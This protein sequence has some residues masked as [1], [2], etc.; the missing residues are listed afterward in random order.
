MSPVEELP[1]AAW[2]TGLAALPG[3]GPARL[4]VLLDGRSADEG[5]AVVRSGV[6][7][8]GVPAETTER[9]RSLAC[10]TDVAAVWAAHLAAGIQVLVPGEPGWPE[11][12]V[13]D[14]EPPPLLFAR[15]DLAALDRPRVAVIG[16]RRC[17]YAGREVARQLG[18]ELAE[19]GVAVVS[20]L[21]L[22]IDGAAHGG[23]LA[24]GAPPV[25]VVATGLD[26]VYPRRHADL[27]RAVGQSGLLLSEYPLGV[28]VE[29]WRFPAR[30]RIIAG[31]ADVVVVVESHAAGG[32]M[33]T[34]ESAIE[35]GRPVMAVP[36]SVRSPASVGT[37]ALLVAGS[38]PVRDATDVLVALGLETGVWERS[39]PPGPDGD[40][41]LV[42]DAVGWEP[43][44]LEQVADRLGCPLGPVAVH[45]VDLERDGW[46]RQHAGWYERCR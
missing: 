4:A 8:P 27:W 11:P 15:G 20:G 6:P 33:H 21:A 44:T 41:G 39:A 32:S 25:G 2:L 5:W 23:A 29:R 38:P 46:I 7:Q 34:V 40:V 24:G 42:L 17:S 18:R 28:W 22:G 36:G 9:W 13:D 19:A 16:T 31:L 10:G 1:T 35:R 14:P 26:V 3:M 45:L 43:V 12:L 37:N 30:N